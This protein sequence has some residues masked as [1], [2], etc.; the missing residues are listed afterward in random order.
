MAQ[1][2]RYA[3]VSWLINPPM[4]ILSRGRGTPEI[5]YL[6]SDYVFNALVLLQLDDNEVAKLSSK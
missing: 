2:A 1:F 6:G 4:T 3:T 5:Q